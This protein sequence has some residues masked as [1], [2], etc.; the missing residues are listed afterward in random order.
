LALAST[1]VLL[2]APPARAAEGALETTT[3]R[4]VN[5]DSVC[6]A[7]EYVAEDL[8]RAEGFTEI[9]YPKAVPAAVAYEM[10]ARGEIDF[11]NYLA[12]G[13][14]ARHI[15]AGRPIVVLAGV[16]VGC[17]ELFAREGIRHIADLKGKSVGLQGAAAS[18]LTLMAASVGL[19]PAADI[20]WVTDPSHRPLD[21]FA[22]GK[23]DAF[24]GFAPQPQELRAR[25]APGHVIVNSSIDRPWSQYFC[26]LLVGNRDYVRKYPVATK[27]VLRAI[28]KAVDLCAA[29][30]E[31]VAR[32]IVDGG[33]TPRYDYARA[34]LSE[35]PYGGWR[36]YDPEDT[37]RF[38]F[39]RM[40]EAGLIKSSP[41]K[42][43]AD[44]T[45]WRFLDELKREL[46]A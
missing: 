5:D 8:L 45:D 12:F 28:L 13:D 39:L 44:A 18:L 31:R 25:H 40:Y 37:M 14:L 43:I 6:I 32:R 35:I 20:R 17:F 11:Y 2:R 16:H 21:L 30:P 19:D 36:D 24:L 9:R 29:E 23:I 46:K 33:F 1:A 15:E 26:C 38:Y 41:G 10:Q 3:V 27:R 7:P 4:L 34:A 22:E 42:L